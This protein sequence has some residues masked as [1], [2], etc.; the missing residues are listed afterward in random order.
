M[1]T[2]TGFSL[3][4]TA[5]GKEFYSLILQGGIEMVKSKATERFY[6]TIK[7]CSISSTFDEETCKAS[8]GEKIPGSIQKQSCEPYTF[9]VKETGEILELNYRWAFVPD[10][11]TLEEVI[12]EDNPAGENSQITIGT[13]F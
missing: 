2:I 7:K 4:T 9:V 13:A 6:A 1:V 10:G 8:I 5:V 11:A 3:R 12:F